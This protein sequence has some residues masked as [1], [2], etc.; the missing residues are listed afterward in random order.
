MSTAPRDQNNIP[1]LLAASS[2]DGTTPTTVWANPSTHRLLVDLG[3]GVT[4]PG[5]STDNAVVRWD[6]TT[7]ATIQNSVVTIADTT[8]IIG[9]A[10]KSYTWPGQTGTFSTVTSGSGVP[11]TTPTALGQ[12]YVDTAGP[13]IYMSTGTSSSADWSKIFD[14]P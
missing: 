5:A 9:V 13:D 14:T 10:G 3:V 6:G 7:G 1:T 2:A 11:A 12:I 4:G 8:G